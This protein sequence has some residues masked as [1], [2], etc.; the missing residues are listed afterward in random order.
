MSN[1]IGIAK[2]CADGILKAI[3]LSGIGSRSVPVDR[4]ADWLAVRRKCDLVQIF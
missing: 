4:L 1:A 3:I 2:V